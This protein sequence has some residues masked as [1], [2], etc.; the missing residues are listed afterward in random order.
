MFNFVV[1]NGLKHF[2]NEIIIIIVTEMI[3]RNMI[4]FLKS[5]LKLKCM[6]I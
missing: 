6:L 1:L 2:N 3:F 5:D 4:P